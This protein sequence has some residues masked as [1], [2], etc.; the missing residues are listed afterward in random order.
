MTS[1]RITYADLQ[2]IAP[3]QYM[4]KINQRL[5]AAKSAVIILLN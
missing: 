3:D 2:A 5:A 4:K 1:R